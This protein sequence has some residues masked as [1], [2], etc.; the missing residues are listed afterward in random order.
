MNKKYLWEININYWGFGS[1]FFGRF[2]TKVLV[3]FWIDYCWYYN[4][5][6]ILEEWIIILV[7]IL[8]FYIYNYIYLLKKDRN[9]RILIREKK[10]VFLCE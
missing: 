1:Y 6:F 10:A 4:Y 3:V 9:I 5:F 8:I 7:N 2:K